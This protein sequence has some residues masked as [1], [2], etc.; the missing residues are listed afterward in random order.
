MRQDIAKQH[1]RIHDTVV[2]LF[3][4]RK[5]FEL[6]KIID[7]DPAAGEEVIVGMLH[8]REPLCP[9]VV[10]NAHFRIKSSPEQEQQNGENEN[11]GIGSRFFECLHDLPPV[12]KPDR[13]TAA[14]R[15]KMAGA[16]AHA[17]HQ[18]ISIA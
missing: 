9:V 17:F 6:K 4:N 14:L 13:Y 18:A 15:H 10:H 2:S 16:L 5:S 12:S 8:D 3:C 1:E 11:P 7:R